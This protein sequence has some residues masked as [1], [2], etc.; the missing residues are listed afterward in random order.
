M[1]CGYSLVHASGSLK[2]LQAVG[3]F[4]RLILLE[5]SNTR[6]GKEAIMQQRYP[7]LPCEEPSPLHNLASVLSAP[8]PV[9]EENLNQSEQLC[10]CCQPPRGHPTGSHC[11]HDSGA[12]TLT[13]S[14]CPP[15]QG[16]VHSSSWKEDHF[17]ISK[18]WFH[19]HSQQKVAFLLPSN[20]MD[21]VKIKPYV[22]TAM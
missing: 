10:P 1:E 18:R 20:S 14:V 4:M 2:F 6:G 19:S 15:R 9:T 17:S 12:S 8:C 3:N 5:H 13:C 21:L 11:A 16:Q 7:S 22:T